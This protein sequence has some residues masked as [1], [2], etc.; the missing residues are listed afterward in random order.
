[1][2][3]K[4]D[5][6]NLLNYKGLYF[7]HFF[8]AINFRHMV[9]VR[10]MRRNDAER[11]DGKAPL[12]AVFYI[13]GEKIR[14]SL[15]VMVTLKEWSS[16]RQSIKGNSKEAKDKNL[17]IQNTIAR[18]NDVVVAFRL[19]SEPITKEKFLARY[20]HPGNNESFYDYAFERLKSF[21]NVLEFSTWRHH[22][23][24]LEKMMA[25]QKELYFSDI[26]T[27]W[28]RIYAAYLKRDLG[29]APGTIA[30]NLSIIRSHLRAAINEGKTKNNPFETFRMPRSEPEVTFLTEE[31]LSIVADAYKTHSLPEAE[32]LALRI[33]LWMAFTGMHISDTRELRIEQIFGEEIHYRRI[34]TKVK[35]SVPLSAPA[36]IIYKEFAG[37]RTSGYLLQGMPSDQ[38]FNR[39]IKI[40]MKKI[41]I[42][43]NV[44]A[45]AARHTFATIF[46]Q[47]TKDIGTLSKLLGHTSVRHTMVYTHIIKQ[48]RIEGMSAFDSFL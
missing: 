47:K 11:K 15:N 3:T 6:G 33:W 4:S 35:V 39:Q 20:K 2:V 7:G 27:D 34:K 18:I 19:A 16:T 1:M 40:A 42:I 14:L 29:N 12:Y 22:K 26:T 38:W 48:T 36:Q 23:A 13:N 32:T 37:D 8:N 30:K 44:S 5:Q 31:E 41:G 25:Y 28:L 46:Y 9:N 24:A 10:I 45:K 17:I 43:K 21:R